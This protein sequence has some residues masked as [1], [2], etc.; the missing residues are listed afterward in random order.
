MPADSKKINDTFDHELELPFQYAYKG[1]LQEASFV[2]LK[3]PSSKHISYCADLKQAFMRALPTD[4]GA[5][6]AEGDKDGKGVDDLDGESIMMLISMSKD[7]DLKTVLIS[8]RELFASGLAFVDGETKMT[9]PMVDE[10]SQDDL[11]N[12]LGK[13]Y[14]NF[15]LASWLRK[16]KESLS[17]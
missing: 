8:A 15:I 9:K 17:T 4:G 12:M 10:M 6:A 13:Y 5:S 7:V 3:A 11:E 1:D 16:M 14:L 2:T